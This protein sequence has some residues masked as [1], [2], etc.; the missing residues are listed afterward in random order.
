MYRHLIKLIFSIIAIL[1]IIVLTSCKNEELDIA[2]KES[3]LSSDTL[4]L[5]VEAF[6]PTSNPELKATMSPIEGS[7]NLNVQFKVGEEIRLFAYQDEQL[8]QLEYSQVQTVSNEGNQ[9]SF[10]IKL[11]S[12]LKTDKPLTLIGYSG[13]RDRDLRVNN[14]SLFLDF[15]TYRTEKL[16][17]FRL[18]IYFRSENIV[19]TE[20]A[21]GE[22]PLRVRFE[23][24]GAYMLL[25]VKNNSSGKLPEQIQA[26][27]PDRRSPFFCTYYDFEQQKQ[28]NSSL[29]LLTGKV[30]DCSS[31]LNKI[32][33]SES[34]SDGNMITVLQWGIPDPEAHINAFPIVYTQPAESGGERYLST[35]L[36]VSKPYPMQR[37]HAYHL[38]ATWN[39]ED[40]ELTDYTFTQPRAVPYVTFTT[41]NP[42]G[43]I[44]DLHLGTSGEARA[45]V[46]VDINGDSV[47]QEDELFFSNYT[48][49]RFPISSQTIQV[50]GIFNYISIWMEQITEFTLNHPYIRSVYLRYNNFDAI[51]LNNLFHSLPELRG[52]DR[53]ELYVSSE[54]NKDIF[55][56]DASIASDKNWVVDIPRFIPNTPSIMISLMEGANLSFYMDTDISDRKNV[57]ADI[58][59]N[60][61]QENEE[62]EVPLNFGFEK[63][64]QNNITFQGNYAILYG[65]IKR[66]DISRNLIDEFVI[67]DNPDIEYLKADYC[68]DNYVFYTTG[69]QHLDLSSLPNLK[70][71]SLQYNAIRSIDYA[72]M[73]KLKYLDISYNSWIQSI[74]L[75]YMPA[76]ETFIGSFCFFK[77]LDFSHNPK[78][79]HI[80]LLHM[81]YSINSNSSNIDNIINT[82]PDR[83][84]AAV[85]GYLWMAD[86]WGVTKA[87]IEAASKKNW[88]LDI[89]SNNPN[90]NEKKGDI[91]KLPIEDW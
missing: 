15:S 79:K 29:N 57:W 39:G 37:G 64:K 89:S 53:G 4:T 86:N 18:P 52:K 83:N 81:D 88:V 2:Y 17:T 69:G 75:S 67:R 34:S 11:P 60:G 23:H 85:P 56:C 16:E 36:S 26:Y 68:T 73:N 27:M 43:E 12:T 14:N 28:H 58:N 33:L 30:E 62:R 77:T 87:H 74:N 1:T 24:I 31:Y 71:L 13:E 49:I 25:H 5:V 38:Y 84:S 21:N 55:S 90:N 91:P 41:D 66:L 78:I 82:L 61:I 19:P 65:K 80:E 46:W 22:E 40:M 32:E 54:Y 7:K 8:H 51:A 50:A 20:I 42:P 70:Y 63:E 76:L 44:F 10:N 59:L 3:G 45:K 6:T 9:C 35:N 72:P 47:K 48:T